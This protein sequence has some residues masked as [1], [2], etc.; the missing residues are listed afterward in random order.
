MLLYDDLVGIV[1]SHVTQ[2]A[3]GSMDQ[4][5]RHGRNPLLYANFTALSSI[6][7]K[8]LPIKVFHCVNREF[9]LFIA[10]NG[11]KYY[12]VIRTAKLIVMIPKHIFWPIIDCFTVYDVL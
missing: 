12:F 1:T 5:I 10:E 8:L 3:D 7:P 11:R 9:R 6:R 2:M 4:W